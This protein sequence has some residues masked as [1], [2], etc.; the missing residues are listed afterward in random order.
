[1]SGA[2]LS[3]SVLGPVEMPD[4]HTEMCGISPCPSMRR[5]FILQLYEVFHL[6]TRWRSK[7]GVC[8]VTCGGGVAKRVLFC[9]RETNGEQE[10]VLEDY[11]CSGFPK[12]TAVV[13]CNTH[14]CP[15][16]W[17]VFR[18]SACSVSCDLGVAQRNVSCVQFIH[19]KEIVVPKDSC[20]AAVK[21]ATTVPCLV[22]VCTFKWEVKPWSQV[23]LSTRSSALES[24]PALWI[25]EKVCFSFNNSIILK[26][27]ADTKMYAVNFTSNSSHTCRVL[28]NAPPS[29]KIRIQALHIGS[30]FNTTNSQ[31]TFIMVQTSFCF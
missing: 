30:V 16:R 26:S 29:V 2:L 10:E 3:A 12:P 15:A 22:Q 14:S 8:S 28:I 13:S 19:G 17:K 20:H 1:M 7:Q 27:D 5:M 31:S 11:N 24:Y 23:D 6:T 4:P 18:T 21:P 9:A 25:A